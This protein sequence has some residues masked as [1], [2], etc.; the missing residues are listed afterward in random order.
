GH[1]APVQPPPPGYAH[2]IALEQEATHS[3]E[4]RD[5]WSRH[6][7]GASLPWWAAHPKRAAANFYCEIPAHTSAAVVSLA[8]ALNVQEK[9]IWCAIYLTLSSL[10]D[11]HDQVTGS[12]VIH[13][14]PEIADAEKTIG[15]FLNS[16]PICADLHGSTWAQ[17]IGRVNDILKDHQAY[18]HYPLARIQAE[19]QLDFS[20]SLFNY[21]NFHVISDGA[22]A[23][24]V[25]G[26]GAFG[27]DE[28]N[29]TFAVDVQKDD[30]A[31][32]HLFRVTVDPTVFDAEFQLRIRTYVANILA[33]MVE[34]RAARIDKLRLLGE[35]ERAGLLAFA[36]GSG[37]P[38][39]AR[40]PPS[41]IEAE[42]DACIHRLIEARVAVQPHAIA[43]IDATQQLTYAELDRCANR[44]A[45]ALR[46]A[47]IGLDQPVAICVERS[48]DLIVGLLGILKA[49]ACYLPLDPAN[50]H[51]RLH[52]VLDDAS[53]RALLTQQRWLEALPQVAVP[54]LAL[55]RDAERL[56]EF[57]TETLDAAEC[58]DHADALAYV[59]YTSG[60]SG[61]P[62]GVA[63][64]HR[65]A[66]N[67]SRFARRAFALSP[68]DAVLQFAT[69][70][71]DASV[72][73]IFPILMAGGRLVMRSEQV[74]TPAELDALLCR[75]RITVL[76]LP[77]AYWHV[78]IA[79]QTAATLAQSPLRLLIVG[80]EKAAAE[81]LR[82]WSAIAGTQHVWL[83]TYGP[84]E[85]TVTSTVYRSSAGD[86]VSA[87]QD[88]R[89]IPIGAPIP[90][91]R[92]YLCD[93]NDALV[94]VGVPGELCIGGIGIARGYVERAGLTAERFVP[95]MYGP[96]GSRVYRTG[97]IGRWRSDGQIEFLGRNDDQVKIRGF[98]VE[99]GEIET[100]LARH[101]GV[102][103]ALVLLRSDAGRA[104][105]LVAYLTRTP[106]S[107]ATIEN[108]RTH[109]KQHLPG[110]ML[111]SAIVPLERLPLTA[112]G[113]VDRAALPAPEAD[114]PKGFDAPQGE[115]EGVLAR[116]WQ[117]IL[118][119]EHVGRED[120]FF[121]LGGHSLA[122]MQLV[123][124]VRQSLGRE[125]ALRHLFAHPTLG[126]LAR[127]LGESS[128]SAEYPIVTVD[129]AQVLPL[130]LAQ[131]RLWIESQFDGASAAY[132]MN[133][134]LELR[135]VL[136]APA[137][138][139][140]LDTIVARHES[141]RTRFVARDGVAQQCIDAPMGFA[142][143]EIDLAAEAPAEQGE[144]VAQLCAQESERP[145][146]LTTGPLARGLLL[147]LADDRHELLLSLHHIVSDGWSMG[148]MLRELGA[149][150]GAYCAGAPDPLL[151]LPIQYADF[152]AWQRQWLSGDTL[153]RHVTYWK[154][155]LGGAP[156]LLELP[157]DR[158]RPAVR[159][160]R[161]D[162]VSFALSAEL[163]A[164]LRAFARR[165][166][167]TV[168]MALHAAFA[169]LLARLSGQPDVVVAVPVANRQRSEVEDLIGFFVNT[170]A[171]RLRLREDMTVAE[172]LSEVKAVTLAAYEHQALP[173]EHVVE[174]LRPARSLSHN[175]LCQVLLAMQNTPESE[176]G[177]PGLTATLKGGATATAQFDLTL[178]LFDS[179]EHVVGGVNYA[180]DLFD[181][182]T[183]ERWVS[184]FH[185]VV[186]QMVEDAARPLQTLD[187]MT[188]RE[189]ER[190]LVEFNATAL[191]CGDVALVHGLIEQH[192]VRSPDLTA[193]VF[194]EERLSYAELDRA[195]NRVAHRLRARGAGPDRLVALY[196]EPGVSLVVGMLGII[197]A[198]AAYL[199]LDPSY[200]ADRLAYMVGD[201]QPSLVVTEQRW[202]SVVPAGS[203]PL[204]CLDADDA[205]TSD[206][207][208]DT[209][210]LHRGNLVYV[211]Y[212]SGSTGR[213]KG[214]MVEHANLVS[215]CLARRAAY[216][217]PRQFLMISPIAFDASVS[218]I[219]GTL[220][221][222]GTLHLAAPDVVVDPVRLL[223][224]LDQSQITDMICVPSL[225][226]NLLPLVAQ[227]AAPRALQRVV[228]AG[229]A[230]APAL[231]EAWRATRFPVELINEYGPTETTVW[232]TAHVCTPDGPNDAVPIGRPIANTQVYIL[233]G[234]GR[235][236]P[237]GVTGEIYIGGAG[238]ARGYHAR[239]ALT[240]ARFV[241]DPFG[242]TPGARL[243]RTGDVGRWR[244]DGTIEYR[245]RN[246]D[247]VKIRGYRIELGEIETRLA[248]HAAVRSAVVT[249]R[250]DTPGDKRLVAYVVPQAEAATPSVDDLRAHL[251]AELP[252]F[253][254][255]A[256]IVVLDALPLSPS[257]KVDRRALPAPEGSAFAQGVYVAP[258]NVTEQQL[259]ELWQQ[260]LGVEPIGRDDN[261]FA[262][263]GHSLLAVK[264]VARIR[265][266]FGRDVTLR[267]VFEAPTPASL[268]ERVLRA[269]SISAQAIARVSRDAALPLS[270]AQE[271]LWFIEQL[272][273][274]GGAYHM[275]L[276]LRLRG[277][278]DVGSL[279]AAIAGLVERH[280]ILRAG[281]TQTDA[282][283]VQRIHAATAFELR[284]E[285]LSEVAE[286][287]RATRLSE[288]A[289]TELAAPFDLGRGPLLRGMLVRLAAQEHVLLLTVH[290][291][292]SDGWSMGILLREMAALYAARR[293][294]QTV[295][296]PP[297]PVQYVDYAAWQ[298][299]AAHG[300]SLQR[301]VAYW[302]EHLHG[303]PP[304][305]QLP[306]DR[307]RPPVQ[308]YRGGC[309]PV[310]L[311]SQQSEQLRALAQRLDMTPFM[312][313]YAAYAV[314][315]AKLSGQQDVVIGVP[316][317]NRQRIELEGVIG[318]FVN[319]LA[320]R[321]HVDASGDARALLAQ[322][323]ETTLA[324]QSHQDAPFEH[325][326][327]ALQPTRSLSY[328]PVFQVMF[329]LQNAGSNGIALDGLYIQ[330]ETIGEGDTA[331]FDL[332]LSLQDAG[333]AFV[334]VL[335]YASD[336]FDA[337][338]AMRWARHYAC[339]VEQ[340]VA[341]LDVRL[342]SLS[343]LD[344]A[345]RAEVLYDFNQTHVDYTPACI[346]SLFEAQAARTPQALALVSGETRWTY[347]ELNR[348]ANRLARH[349]RSLGVVPDQAVGLCVKR[350][351][352]LAVGVLAILKAGGAY[353]PLD[354]NYPAERLHHILNDADPAVVLTQS[355]L[356]AAL[357]PMRASIVALDGI[358]SILAK[359]SPRNLGTT[360]IGLR[361]D[362]LAYLIYTSG[363]TGQ[364]KGVMVEHRSTSNLIQWAHAAQGVPAFAHTLAS[365]SLNF[366]LA[367]YELFVPWCC[368]GCVHLVDNALAVNAQTAVGLINT[369]PSAISALLDA[370][371]VPQSI[372]VVN[373]AGEALSRAV[374]ERLFV[375]T[376][377][378]RVCNL[379]GPSETT[380]YSTWVA[381][382]RAD[383]FDPTIGRPIANTQVYL[384]DAQ[385]APVPVGVV[386]EL[387]IGGAGVARGYWRRA[388]LTQ[389]RFLPNPFA[390]GRM[391]RTG[392]LARW[393]P[394]GRIEY[395]GR[396]DSQVKLRGFRIELG[397]I[398][399]RLLQ[400]MSIQAAIVLV[401]EDEPG[402][403]R[404]VAYF[405]ASTEAPNAEVL[406]A[407]LQVTLPDYMLPSLF[408]E[409]D[410]LPL[411]PNGKVDRS[412]LPLPHQLA[413]VQ[414]AYLAPRTT[415]ER[416]LCEIWAAVL[417]VGRVG[418][419]DN[420]FALGGDSIRS[421]QIVRAARAAGLAV[422][423]IDLF[424][425]QTV[426]EL[427]LV[428]EGAVVSSNVQ[429]PADLTLLAAPM[430]G[431]ERP[432]EL[433]DWYPL[434]PMQAVM[435]EQ[436]EQNWRHG[437]GVYH[438]QQWFRLAD[439][440]PDADAMQRA[441]Q[442]LVAM[443]PVLRTVLLR[444]ADGSVVQGIRAAQT[445]PFVRHD[446][447]EFNAAERER[448]VLAE[449]ARDRAAPFAIDGQEA[450]LRCHW[451]RTG[452]HEI[453]LLLS[454]HHAIDDGWGNQRLL[455]LW[456]DTY[457]RLRH[458]QA[459]A[460]E[461]AAN[462]YKEFVALTLESAASVEARAYW[463]QRRFTPT[464]A[465][466]LTRG[467]R[468]VQ[469]A[470][471]RQIMLDGATGTRL[472][473]LAQRHQVSLKAV[474]LSAYL[475][476]VATRIGASAT[477]V[478]VVTNG[479]SD[480]LSDPLG[481]LGLYWTMLP[482]GID[483]ASDALDIRLRA[484][485]Q[486]LAFNETHA[487]FPLAEIEREQGG[488]SLFFATFN[489]VDFQ[490]TG[491]SEYEDP[492]FIA[493][494]GHDKFHYP[495]NY[496]FAPSA[497][498]GSL[499]IHVHYDNAYFDNL[500]IADMSETLQKTLV[501]YSEQLQSTR[502]YETEN[503]ATI[504]TEMQ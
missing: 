76:D 420:F 30:V 417:R 228:V 205:T 63:V 255:P 191:P 316:V 125:L 56:Q 391:Y 90:Q 26:A 392:D 8:A 343:L 206:A 242:A 16:L 368:G 462:V 487:L 346:G 89:E 418:V 19:S 81:S 257:G 364:P 106:D 466:L 181:R 464:G 52:Y 98:R 347:A 281:F 222:G 217:T 254:L 363:S 96:A 328:S 265:D 288:R 451:F 448:C 406:R 484:L 433:E 159:S 431:S 461:P 289:R 372:E 243:Y 463:S 503:A 386:G 135:G 460:L 188:A 399:A 296:L 211:I 241:A 121:E 354:P 445:V 252:E 209:S 333:G 165:T 504:D 208:C 319:T 376:K 300:A 218:G 92:L 157:I 234:H 256:A 84:T 237:I 459:P 136:D 233:D 250:E 442:A 266:G 471:G 489:F 360:G 244:D 389:E 60:S 351:A 366:D 139:R 115:I 93:P 177:L 272:G 287:Q 348:R 37:L 50:S 388:A 153:Q 478:G 74:P 142:L 149:L 213:P 350:D 183:I 454:I 408:V 99:L 174:A 4:Q 3:K 267:D 269:D 439:A 17:L 117:D 490:A 450:L 427:A 197:K 499:S 422:A 465:E 277:V 502:Q 85:A 178:S 390:P 312:V 57:S 273:S 387:Y 371:D 46:A 207:P 223:D 138:R 88:L 124:R 225:Y 154:E 263:G 394:D 41:D 58:G 77:T 436:Y 306:T 318:F 315:L 444:R 251:R 143:H 332:A 118:Q 240:A 307:P 49:G 326:V 82:H 126:A 229:E 437:F 438:L 189:R 203:T 195:A 32:T 419:H 249:A 71:F 297:L 198:G 284:H 247:Q 314:L 457:Q 425:H 130:S 497:T 199:P 79:E 238:V 36:T 500:T 133:T 488:N 108:L 196:L 481:G 59:I 491:V 308:T 182:A 358:E 291:I 468:E 305:L 95:D 167:N 336:L 202:M 146:D 27:Y 190:V 51:E 378:A 171:L 330:V 226:Q 246:D 309:V 295:S 375:E 356:H 367:V 379:Y 201:A 280:E 101:A 412:R 73:E 253:M 407:H 132:H 449:V 429:A 303:A 310:A 370:A 480:R 236:V 25:V 483:N 13:G 162:T 156:A 230:C 23:S 324:G 61:R 383:G 262:L 103:E 337:A 184:Q 141:L 311:G 374:V 495:L 160:Y 313:L 475:E 144:R 214:V 261:F 152:A 492:R 33:A 329:A 286:P 259:A 283:A 393:L 148:V 204:L 430:S 301:H 219:F 455:A 377:A 264:L 405:V 100:L 69:V 39:S 21:V 248:Q 7:Q 120:N 212:T 304:L 452:E 112:N 294:G 173:F 340:L 155:A 186:A 275:P 104:P 456:F 193:V 473:A 172:L 116:L 373:L 164:Q 176:I 338:T 54:V 400:H 434:A 472:R 357:P 119:R 396:N 469:N 279:E 6:L 317:A 470:F 150:Y 9:S 111:P 413:N 493:D 221:N 415:L 398:E 20:A 235:A 426:A 339:V 486:Q 268:A 147:R 10:L 166:D 428:L 109:L 477:T 68:E 496:L 276:T 299:S 128:A 180:T 432:Q 87:E 220:A 498:D 127:Q 232:A 260:L 274:T 107:D 15:L 410:A 224:V 34:T 168:F 331:Q 131:Q 335:N 453:E 285:D 345:G 161:G 12:I 443:Q 290:H 414:H 227:R 320:L 140:A 175:P 322:V 245:G 66:V 55:D 352:D 179:G 137:L 70:C 200:P 72:E 409:L 361:P 75:E 192:V 359:E 365:T 401:R 494:A 474:L 323:K 43:V 327:D 1:A 441:L 22:Q 423:V 479:R 369:V 397:E 170:L 113:K 14:R 187:L 293:S 215:F 292:V 446:L 83:N 151:P 349:L 384:L 163:S 53:P 404:L 385:C 302:A 458:G 48:V 28:T 402:D 31:G 270:F 380:T 102:K 334:G 411:T 342:A 435:V 47:G 97:D 169:L 2:Y 29:Y 467:V 341:N 123:A 105:R 64:S 40:V 424:K 11:G 403:R 78:W 362:H 65:N 381:M 80:G 353:L 421:L 485:Q 114:L 416:N 122:A 210:E 45:R 35:R 134:R 355:S 298:R 44:V 91:T 325:V 194:Q 321:T 185:T 94:P 158:P 395:L 18:R 447:R 271:R 62:K 476:L 482:V 38:L 110:Y 24:S 86:A 67:H 231:V 239:A 382:E 5:Y 145:F 129:R 501:R 42:R 258:Q 440:A 216:G 344:V 282:D 278:L